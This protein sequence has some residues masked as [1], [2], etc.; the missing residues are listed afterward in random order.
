[1][2]SGERE[3]AALDLKLL[4]Y[5]PAPNI[6]V[7]ASPTFVSWHEGAEGMSDIFSFGAD[8]TELDSTVYLNTL[9]HFNFAKYSVPNGIL[10]V[11]WVDMFLIAEDIGFG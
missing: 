9:V 3:L 5:T 7:R 4:T 1:M 11:F 2:K 6:G 10:P 8:G